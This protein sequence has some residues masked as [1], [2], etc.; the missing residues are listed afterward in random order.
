[1]ARKAQLASAERDIF[2]RILTKGAGCS[3]IE[4]WLRKRIVEIVENSG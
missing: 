2:A 4:R 1:M 3:K